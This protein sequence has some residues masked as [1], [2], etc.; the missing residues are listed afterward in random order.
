[1]N[2]EIYS[3][4]NCHL[5][6]EAKAVLLEVQKEIPFELLEVDIEK[7][8]VLKE[9]FKT[10]VPVVFVDGRK[11]FTHRVDR[12]ELVK[13][14]ERAR[15]FSL[16]TLD[17]QKT[18]SRTAPVSRTTKWAFAIIAVGSIAGLL[19]AKGYSKFVLDRD[20][21]VESLNLIPDGRLAPPFQV[22]LSDQQPRT[23]ANYKGKLLVLNYFATWCG[24]CREEL[25]S[26]NQLALQ[27]K[28]ENIAVLAVSVQEDWPTLKKFF[29]GQVPAFEL[30]LDE[31]GNSAAAYERRESLMFPETF[32]V[33]PAGQV[34]AKIEGARDWTDPV[35]LRWL[36]RLSEG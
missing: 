25:P 29:G 6:E 21:A 34:V 5:C 17:P 7:D 1:M 12:E 36:R 32:I 27:T 20:R 16:G 9:R 11:L 14:L 23:L 10:E 33:T 31:S 8:P 22:V 24:P 15:A 18:L 26:M 35:M 2:V 19:A 3:K 4:P 13:R 30:G 28:G